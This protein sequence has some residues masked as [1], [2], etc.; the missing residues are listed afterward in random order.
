MS[1]V[2]LRKLCIPLQNSVFFQEVIITFTTKYKIKSLFISLHIDLHTYIHIT[3]K[4]G[5]TGY[6]L[7][8]Q[9]LEVDCLGSNPGST[10]VSLCLGANYSKTQCLSIFSVT[11]SVNKRNKS[12]NICKMFETAVQ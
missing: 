8:T 6:W 10:L 3:D 2:D 4:R 11:T 7:R 9:T 12:V 5:C 1:K